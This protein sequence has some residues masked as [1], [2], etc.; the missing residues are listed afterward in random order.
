MQSMQDLPN[1]K[2]KEKKSARYKAEKIHSN[3]PFDND[4][5]K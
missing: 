2:I 4:R 5:K 1:K 3:F